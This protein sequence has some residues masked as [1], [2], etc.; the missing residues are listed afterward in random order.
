MKRERIFHFVYLYATFFLIIAFLTSCLLML[1]TTILA[2]EL[3]VE[4]TRENMTRAAK[5]TFVNVVLLSLILTVIDYLRRRM[6]VERP[7]RH[8]TEGAERMTKGDFNVRIPTLPSMIADPALVQIIYCFNRLAEELSG[9]ETLREDFVASVSHEMKTPLAVIRNH[10][11]LL[12]NPDLTAEQRREYTNVIATSAS[13]LSSMMSN[14]LKL[15]R[16]EN[17]QIYPSI[18]RLNLTERL[19]ECLLSFEEVWERKQIEIVSDLAED[20]YVMG[21]DELLDVVWNNLISNALKFTPEGGRVTLSLTTTQTHAQFQISDTGVGMSP[22]VGAHIFEK[23]YQGDTSHRT[24][25]N[26]LGLALVRRVIDIHGADI[27]VQ[28]KVGE[29]ATFTVSLRRA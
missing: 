16:L 4:L 17:Q 10:A 8:I 7:V 23:F 1:Y 22:E 12:E 20:V 25:G 29:G 21:D 6:F 19:C 18:S 24:E 2:E 15:S 13:R 27:T 14:I 3:G 28:S 5:V 11:K 9:V 26:G